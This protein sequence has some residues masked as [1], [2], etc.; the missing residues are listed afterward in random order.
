M[1]VKAKPILFNTEMVRAI[2]DG[3]KTQTRRLM[4]PQPMLTDSIQWNWKDRLWWSGD[5]GHYT[6]DFRKY[7]PISVGDILW[8]REVFR[9]VCA[10]ER[11]YESGKL[12]SYQ[13]IFGWKY[14]ADSKIRF[15][16]EKEPNVFPWDITEELVWHPSIHMPKK[17]ARIF[18]RVKDVSV[19]R[20]QEVNFFDCI[21]EGVP[22][23]QFEDK[24]IKNFAKLWDETI[25]KYDRDQYGWCANPWV[26]VIT[27]DRCDKP[28]GWEE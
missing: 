11:I 28:E 24:I 21:N 3:K 15:K 1:T 6:V 26:W 23:N 14:M 5:V 22:Y 17:A 4:K 9:F 8:I 25:K 7:A 13:E 27:F 10:T 2:L 18:L 20:L 12:T 16:G 19:N